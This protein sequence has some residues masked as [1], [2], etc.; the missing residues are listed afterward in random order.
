MNETITISIGGQKKNFRT[1]LISMSVETCYN[2]PSM[3]T[4]VLEDDV[5]KSGNYKYIDDSSTYDFGKEVKIE[6]EAEV[7]GPNGKA[8]QKDVLIVG[9]ITSL[10]PV[11]PETAT[12]QLIIRGYDKSHRLM[13]G[14]KTRTFL[15]KKDS[16]LASTLAQEAG[17]SAKVDA[18]SYVYEYVMQ[19]NQTNWEF[20]LARAQLNG[21]QIRVDEKNLY[22]KKPESTSS[23]PE[24]PLAYGQDL[25]SFE[26]RICSMGQLQKVGATGWDPKKKEGILQEVSSVSQ[27]FVGIGYG[28]KGSAAAKKAFSQYDH[29]ITDHP[30]TTA[31]EAKALAESRLLEAESTFV[32][33]TGICPVG[34]PRIRAGVVVNI[35]N[36]GTRFSGKYLVTESRHEWANG[37]Y[38]VY[39]SVTGFSDPT[40][41]HLLASGIQN[42][43]DIKRQWGVVPALVTSL[44]DPDKEGKVKVKYPWLPKNQ[45]AEIESF[46]ARVAV[47]SAGN[48]RGMMFLPEVNDEVLV[49]FE[50]GDVNRAYIVGA[51]W[52]G[53]DKLPKHSGD[54][55]QNGKVNQRIIRSRTGHTIVLDDTEGKEQIII[56]DKTDKNQIIFNSTEKSITFE[57]EGDLVFKAKGKV[58][59]DSGQD[60]NLTS[61]GAMSFDSKQKALIKAMTSELALEASGST[62]KGTMVDIAGNT[63]TSLKGNAMVEIQGGMVKIN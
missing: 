37:I 46:W 16:D 62:L 49:A 27:N 21:Y 57:C 56:K 18:T 17:L 41:A 61:K 31:D 33:A 11:Y 58:T 1:D 22:F 54:I 32:Q 6:V 2:L 4:I 25:T 42:G 7:N 8:T 28:S 44:D 34:D 35:T 48:E 60:L 23:T 55:V 43:T 63:K 24:I 59:V 53:K 13:R 20:L 19:L 52:N 36:L 50:Q 9:E 14:T 40:S 15:K 39:F 45:G 51:L 10:E 12:P 29:Y 38:R 47:P 30:L 5:N 3:F 26:P